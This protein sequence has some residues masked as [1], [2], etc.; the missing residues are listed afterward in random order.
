MGLEPRNTLDDFASYTGVALFPWALEHWPE[1]KH[2]I[3][4]I[5]RKSAICL[6]CKM[7]KV[8][9]WNTQEFMKILYMY[10][11]AHLSLCR[12]DQS[13]ILG[14]CSPEDRTHCGSR[15]RHEIQVLPIT[16]T[17]IWTEQ[18]FQGWEFTHAQPQSV[19][20]LNRNYWE[21]DIYSISMWV[22]NLIASPLGA[23]RAHPHCVK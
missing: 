22:T 7:L 1:H 19:S 5:P 6:N 14:Q 21:R 18:T 2:G 15:G 8:N 20:D 17:H 10:F 16:M 12:D 3:V 9:V 4:S 13:F 23:T 11:S